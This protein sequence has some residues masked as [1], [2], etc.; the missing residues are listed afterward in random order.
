MDAKT[1]PSEVIHGVAGGTSRMVLDV[2]GPT[3]EFLTS[4]Q[5]RTT[6]FA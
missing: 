3:V 6:T 5:P 2:L 4:P 1:N